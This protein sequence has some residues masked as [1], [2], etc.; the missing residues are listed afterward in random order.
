MLLGTPHSRRAQT[1]NVS[2]KLPTRIDSGL[3]SFDDVHL[4]R[5]THKFMAL[6]KLFPCYAAQTW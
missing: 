1:I 2:A 5:R 4:I 3:A 6:A